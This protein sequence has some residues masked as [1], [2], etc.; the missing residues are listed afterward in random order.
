MAG[1][2]SKYGSV[3]DQIDASIEGAVKLSRRQLS[4]GESRTYYEECESPIPEVR[5]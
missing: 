1:G 2:W 4:M 3:Q 5:L